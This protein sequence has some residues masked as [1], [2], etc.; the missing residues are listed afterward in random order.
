MIPTRTA[1]ARNT[2]S[3]RGQSGSAAETIE[4]V[5]PPGD[6]ERLDRYLAAFLA[7]SRR[8]HAAN[9]HVR[10][11]FDR[12][13]EFVLNGGKRLRPR[14]ALA[15][16]RILTDGAQ[17]PPRAVW[18]A[19]ASL[20]LFHAFMLAHDDLI[21]NS[22]TRRDR[23]T[24]HEA[25]R[26]DARWD[27]TDGRKRSADLGLIAGDLLCALGMRL[28]GRSGLDDAAM[29]RAHRLIADMLL[30]TGVGEALDVL[31]GDCPLG[32]LNE[33]QILDAY[34]GKTAR[35]SVSGPLVLGASLAGA[36]GSICKAI[37]KFGDLLGLGFQIQNDL[38]ALTGADP[39][40]ECPD[41]DGGKRT[42]IL[43]T[44]YDRLGDAG[45]HAM[46]AALTA[47]IGPARRSVLLDLI[48]ESGAL[49]ECRDRL[50]SLRR[51]AVSALSSAPLDSTRRRAFLGLVA[52]I[53]Q[54]GGRHCPPT[55]KN[56][57]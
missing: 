33:G 40:D 28:L 9:P 10:P 39:R 24:L 6:R 3:H 47:P 56:G 51:E 12:A 52:M 50:A 17:P 21:D 34:L 29:G 15:S 18:R 5:S 19:A 42:W 38:D 57:S 36:D 31:Y 41:L 8:R 46:Q 43:W 23:P 20:E 44:A 14:L 4:R 2:P 55:K 45:R 27:D 16:Y 30:E 49:A 48:A 54:W 25:I 1:I 35:Y 26:R 7:E 53:P 32:G 22:L 13:A 37:G 11:T